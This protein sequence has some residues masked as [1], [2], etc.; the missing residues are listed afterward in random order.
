MTLG[1]VLWVI[2]IVMCGAFLAISLKFKDKAGQSFSNYA[3]GGKTFPVYLI[4]FTQFATIMGVG[5]F[6]GHAGSGYET[7]LPWMAFIIGEQGSKV[8]FALFIAEFAGKFTYNTF[9][10]LLDDLIVRDKITRAI[11]GILAASIMI[12]WVGGQGKAL[13]S[14]FNVITGVDPLPIIILFSAVFIVYTTLGGVYSVVWTD[15]LQGILVVIFGTV[16]YLFAFKQVDFSIAEIGTRL[17]ALGKAEMWQFGISDPMKIVNMIVTGTIGI[18]VAQIYWQRCF[19]SKNPKTAKNGLLYSG[20]IAIAAVML[21]ALVGMIIYTMNQ[22]LEPGNAMAW[23]MMNRVPVAIAG[24]I[25]AL[26][27]AAGMSSADSDLN[28]ASVLIVNDLIKPFKSEVTDE[29]LVKYAKIITALIGIFAALGAIFASSILGLFSRAYSM[30]G[31]GLVPLMIIG[32]IWKENPSDE[33]E[34][35]KR[36]SKVTPWAAR[37][38]VIVGAVLSQI[39]AL[40]SNKVLIALAVSAVCIIIISLATQKSSDSKIVA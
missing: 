6:V 3:I 17:N 22:D 4:F 29:Q 18:L 20:I 14:I 2:T 16:F 28:A 35:G 36:N 24:M 5:N 8:I 11:A 27:L 12:A 34:K 32:L 10:E 37:I 15:L 26:V 9:P 39:N 1:T 13:G 31:A 30:A 23:F 38:G 7:G 25:F 21:T 19:A 40:G 33:H